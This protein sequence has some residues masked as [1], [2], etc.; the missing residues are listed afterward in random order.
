MVLMDVQTGTRRLSHSPCLG[1]MER[2]GIS[3][4]STG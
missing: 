3:Y 4:G 1:R 2:K